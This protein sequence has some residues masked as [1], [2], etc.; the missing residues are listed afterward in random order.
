MRFRNFFNRKR[1]QRRLICVLLATLAVLSD[2]SPLAEGSPQNDNRTGVKLTLPLEPNS[3]RFAVI[4]D[5]GTGKRPQYDIGQELERYR[6][7]VR[8]DFAIMLGDNIYGSQDAAGFKA[9][10]EDP[11][12]VLLDAGVK[13]YASLGNHDNPNQRLYKPFNMG[14]KRYYSFKKGKVE[15]FVLD[16]NYM[17]R[18]QLQWLESQLSAST[19]PWKIC[20]FHHPLYSNSRFHGP[21][22][23][24]RAQI[25]PLFEKY[26]VQV[27]FSGHEHVY[28]RLK[29]QHGI[30]YF[31]LGSSGQLRPHD[32]RASSDTAKGFD[33]DQTFALVEVS[34]DTLYF[35]T[36]ARNGETVDSGV[37][38]RRSKS[39]QAAGAN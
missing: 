33:T 31:V 30:Y 5:S 36:I 7:T 19:S 22:T 15:F 27:V 2:N 3:V 37:V 38:E 23:D 1:M 12:R 26:N 39:A 9:K 4:G 13:F 14:G 34:N 10:F 6:Q 29:P 28:E 24:L 11:Y 32:L 18:E 25:E 35:Q 21:D 17:D 8:F 16:S 20:Y